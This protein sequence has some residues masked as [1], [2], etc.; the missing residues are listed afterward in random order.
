MKSALAVPK[1]D[2][3]HLER[4]LAPNQPVTWKLICVRKLC[5]FKNIEHKEIVT[6]KNTQ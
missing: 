2:E 4:L 3:S 6:L 1:T 5:I